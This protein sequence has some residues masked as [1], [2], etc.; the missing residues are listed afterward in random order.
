M[1]L[2]RAL[3]LAAAASLP[4]SVAA[5]DYPSDTVR[6]VVPFPPGGS[7][8]TMG[9]PL[10]DHLRKRWN[11]PVI[12]DNRPGA[13]TIIGTDAVAKAAPDGLTLLFTA[14]VS[15]TSNP[16]LFNKLPFD[17]I[18]DL[19]PI[20]QLI[21]SPMILAIN[22]SLEVDTL[23]ELVDLAKREPHRINYAS[24]GTGTPA[25]LLFEALRA[26]TGAELTH[27]PYKGYGPALH[28]T[29]SGEV[30]IT[31]VSAMSGPYFDA[32]KLKP[33]AID[34]DQ[35]SPLYPDLPTFTEAGYGDIGLRAWFGMFAPKGTP[36]AIIDQVRDDVVQVLQDPQFLASQVDGMGF[37]AVG[38]TPTEF[39]EFIQADYEYKGD[40]IRSTGVKIE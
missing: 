26:K 25:H 24:F 21:N 15:I 13:S 37:T 40:L 39:A 38:N 20:V 4:L 18:Q 3:V 12:V 7:L 1:K 5:N 23:Q 9:R 30:P 10:A 22:P 19:V 11:K 8:D 29:L 32:G 27:I 14:D 35:R 33:I 16:F 28:A 2:V 31:L 34:R 36:Q 6:L 17:P